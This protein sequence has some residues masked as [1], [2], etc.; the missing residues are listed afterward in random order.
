MIYQ[1]YVYC[2]RCVSCLE[3]C[4]DS[5]QVFSRMYFPHCVVVVVVVVV[6]CVVCGVRLHTHPSLVS[7]NGLEVC[8]VVCIMCMRARDFACDRACVRARKCFCVCVSV[9]VIA[10]VSSMSL[11]RSLTLSLLALLSLL[12]LPLSLCAA[13]CVHKPSQTDVW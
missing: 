13:V 7:E 12:S 11:S 2:F 3:R 9:S 5:K 1:S 8:C 6:W 10:S 4:S